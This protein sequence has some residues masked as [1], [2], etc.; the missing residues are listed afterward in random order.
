MKSLYVNENLY[1]V[2]Q[3]P[4]FNFP[5]LLRYQVI[6]E[7]FC[8]KR[9]VKLSLTD[10]LCLE[11]CQK[12]LRSLYETNS[13]VKIVPWDQSSAVRIDD[14]YT[15]LSWLMDEKKPNGV[16]QTEIEHYTDIF[17]GGRPNHTP[18]RILVHGRP[19]ICLLYTS[20]SPR[21]RTRSRM[22]SSA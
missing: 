11:E 5:R 1:F 18:K 12:Q 16:T 22:P 6:N 14:I 10:S 13:K 2:R 9:N 19:G 21:D 4:P 15:Q 8:K 3:L 7:Q 17:D 20:P